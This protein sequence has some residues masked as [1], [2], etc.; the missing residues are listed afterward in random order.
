PVGAGAGEVFLSFL[1]V[2]LLEFVVALLLLL[3]SCSVEVDATSGVDGVSVSSVAAA[4]S[5]LISSS[6]D[7]NSLSS[8]SKLAFFSLRSASFDLS[9]F[10]LSSTSSIC[11]SV[12]Y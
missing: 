6:N 2:L 4:I 1:L 3:D 5:A 11:V 7:A 8:D 10:F 9:D 12:T